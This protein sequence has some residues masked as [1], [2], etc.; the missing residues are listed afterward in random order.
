VTFQFHHLA[1]LLLL[2]ASTA[3]LG[4]EEPQPEEEQRRR[5][6]RGSAGPRKPLT[7]TWQAPAVLKVLFEKH[8]PPPRPR[9]ASAERIA[10]PVDTRRAPARAGIA[11]S[12]GYFSATVEIEFEAE[13]REHATSP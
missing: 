2:A 4:Q 3:A 8:L 5:R 10:A 6:R 12:E 1:C 9:A 11:A 7:V 13:S